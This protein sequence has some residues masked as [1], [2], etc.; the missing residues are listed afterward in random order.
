LLLEENIFTGTADAVCKA[1]STEV[2]YFSSDCEG[3]Q[4]ALE[5]SCCTVC[6]GDAEQS[7]NNVF[8]KGNLNPTWE[9]GFEREKYDF[10]EGFFLP[11]P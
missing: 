7:C 9:T 4:P 1:E 2:T 3:T 6:C 8:W 11:Q 5:C 10:E